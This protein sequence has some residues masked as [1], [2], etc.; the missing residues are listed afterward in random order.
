LIYGNSTGVSGNC[1]SWGNNFVDGNTANGAFV[2]PNIT[3]L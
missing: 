3:Q 1:K 2:L